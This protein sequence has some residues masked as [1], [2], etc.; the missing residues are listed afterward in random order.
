MR[1]DTIKHRRHAAVQWAKFDKL[2]EDTV[3]RLK[4]ADGDREGIEAAI[5][6][7]IER[8]DK[9]GASPYDLWDFFAISSPGI[10]ERAG[11]C[12]AE[13][14]RMVAVFDRLSTERFGS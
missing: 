11:Y 6:R 9:F 14:E 13:G 10:P 2:V 1:T 4:A 7:Y 8:G 12:G 5:R 3:A